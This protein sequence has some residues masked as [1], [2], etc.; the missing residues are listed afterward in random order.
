VF[1]AD[2][3]RSEVEGD[4]LAVSEVLSISQAGPSPYSYVLL[5]SKRTVR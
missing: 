4:A 5:R 1:R 2:P 3:K